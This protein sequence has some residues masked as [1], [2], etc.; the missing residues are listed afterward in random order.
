MNFTWLIP[1]FVAAYGIYMLCHNS[2]EL[3][4]RPI[5]RILCAAPFFIA[6]SLISAAIQLPVGSDSRVTY[7]IA[8]IGVGFGGQLVLGWLGIVLDQWES[9]NADW[10]DLSVWVLFVFA[11]IVLPILLFEFIT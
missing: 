3:P 9:T 11:N 8:A 4:R 10:S 7:V 2:K 1:A 5:S 6:A